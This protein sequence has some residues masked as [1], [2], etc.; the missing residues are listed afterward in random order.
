M[1][2]K[3][4]KP[5][6][7]LMLVLSNYP[8]DP[9]VR[10]EAEALVKNGYKV[11]IIC[12]SSG[13]ELPE[14]N[15]CGIKVFRIIEGHTKDNF[16][17]Y[18]LLSI[19]FF[20]KA[21]RFINKLSKE[22]RY[23]VIQVHNMPDYL[24]FTTLLQKLRGVPVILDL[25]DIMKEL[26]K[27]RWNNG[28]KK[29]FL[30]VI[31]V[32]EKLSWAYADAL[33]T[34]SYGFKQCLLERGVSENKITL[35]LNTADPEI[36]NNPKTDWTF[37]RQ[38]P[39]LV[40][41]GTV[42]ERFGIH[43]AIEAVNILKERYPK[44]RFDI[45]GNYQN[46]YKEKL[47][48]LVSSCG[49]T[50]NIFFHEYVSL[51]K[52]SEVIRNSNFGIVPYLSDNFMDLALSTK[53][54]EYVLMKLPVIASELPSMRTIFNENQVYYFNQ[55]DPKNLAY[56]MKEIFSDGIFIEKKVADAAAAYKD[57]EWPLMVNKY[58]AL[59]EKLTCNN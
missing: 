40:Y 58:T 10:R 55:N 5:K 28:L 24:V 2:L 20:F 34:T 50:K 14:E 41:H 18:I 7:I 26:F 54:F 6:K 27:S 59:I 1:K 36:F 4:I 11:D 47:H 53:T 22:N 33:I 39:R 49:L 38:N 15:F 43:V 9:R 17:N 23:A 37:S 8:N 45:Y 31:S 21:A 44:V 12:L 48:E 35:I 32:T 29:I 51:E 52:I 13:K 46:G 56:V 16:I 3:E 25:H 57:V 42:A 30:P 19:R